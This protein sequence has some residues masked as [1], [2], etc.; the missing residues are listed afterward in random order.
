MSATI[1]NSKFKVIHTPANSNGDPKAKAEQKPPPTP[2][3]ERCTNGLELLGTEFA[4]VTYVI[5]GIIPEGLS[6]LAGKPKLGKS[7]LTLDAAIAVATGG[8]ALGQKVEQGDVLFLALEDNQRR[9]KKRLVKLMPD[10]ADKKPLEK[11]TIATTWRKSGEG[12]IEDIEDWCKS[13]TKPRLIVV[14]TLGCI[15]AAADGKASAYQDDVAALRPIHELANAR[16]LAVIVV[17]H[18]RK[19]DA[20]DPLDQVSGTTGL[21]GTADTILVLDRRAESG[22]TLKGRGR[23]L[24]DDIDLALGFDRETCRF[25]VR[26]SATEVR[27][28]TERTT[29]LDALKEAP[30]GMTPSELAAET[31]MKAAN[32]KKLLGKMVRDGQVIK[33]EGRGRYLHPDVKGDLKD[34]GHFG[35]F[36]H[37]DPEDQD[38]YPE[39]LDS[40]GLL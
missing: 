3:R 17:H 34:S 36:G 15:R 22:L 35:H 16:G 24:E 30:N 1:P 23:D 37:H 5:P 4:P 33:A 6:L 8:H 25:D 9:L 40:Y 12:L 21:A 11:M 10:F 19:M 26:G 27:R 39:D 29:I 32:V 13:V 18:V 7:W 2:W 20:E 38:S 14:D 28:S 31:E